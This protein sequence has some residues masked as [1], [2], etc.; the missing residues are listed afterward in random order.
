MALPV[1]V[2]NAAAN[3]CERTLLAEKPSDWRTMGMDAFYNLIP[4][5]QIL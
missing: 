1:M 4:L 2:L 5:V 3:Q